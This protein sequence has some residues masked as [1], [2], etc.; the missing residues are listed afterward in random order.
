MRQD[1]IP[2]QLIQE[3]RDQ[4]IWVVELTL[5]DPDWYPSC[6]LKSTL[7]SQ[8]LAFVLVNL[9]VAVELK[10]DLSLWKCRVGEIGVP[11]QIDG[12]LCHKVLDEIVGKY[13][14]Q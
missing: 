7:P 2:S 5:I 13:A 8:K 12:E 9:P 1:C 3:K 4:C 11:S 14:V 10:T 6:L